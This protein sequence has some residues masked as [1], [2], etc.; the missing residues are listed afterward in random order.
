M[1]DS[2]KAFDMMDYAIFVQKLLKLHLPGFV[3]N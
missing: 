2:S 3:F 1:I